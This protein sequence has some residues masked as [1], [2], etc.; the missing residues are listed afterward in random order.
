MKPSIHKLLLF[1]CHL[2]LS[3]AAEV[4]SNAEE[5]SNNHLSLSEIVI[6]QYP[7]LLVGYFAI[8]DWSDTPE[9]LYAYALGMFLAHSTPSLFQL[10]YDDESENPSYN[11][12][13]NLKRFLNLLE[14]DFIQIGL[15]QIQME[16]RHKLAK[17]CGQVLD[18]E[19][20]RMVMPVDFDDDLDEYVPK[21]KG[22]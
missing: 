1:I 18:F 6:S 7:E 2:L 14:I 9:E 15:P 16:K 17:F 22:K 21:K 5:Q 4:P 12:S 10:I 19:K 8:G 20:L 13:F 11:L 3:N